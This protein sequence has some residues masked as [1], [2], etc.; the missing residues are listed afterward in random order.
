MVQGTP[1]GVEWGGQHFKVT[2]TIFYY[3]LTK[4]EMQNDMLM[5]LFCST[6]INPVA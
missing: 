6:R 1:G 3:L 4:F 2:V 5:I